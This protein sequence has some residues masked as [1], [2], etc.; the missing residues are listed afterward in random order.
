MPCACLRPV[1]L[2]L[3]PLVIQTDLSHG[4]VG[5]FI[6]HVCTYGEIL[7][8]RH[9]G[10]V[11]GEALSPEREPLE[12]LEAIKLQIGSDAFSAQ[13][14]QAPAPPGEAMVKRAW[15]VRYSELP[16]RSECLMTLQSWDTAS[17]GGPV[18]DW[19]VCTTW[20]LATHK[21]RYLADVWRRVD[22]PALRTA[23]RALAKQWNANRV[24][25]E[26]AGA[27]TSLVQELKGLVPGINAVK[28]E[29]DKAAVASAKIEAG[30]VLLP[31]RASWLPD[32][33]A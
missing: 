20:I 8:F 3:P 19:S 30:Q 29:G 24:L 9:N 31:E 21:R 32:L 16:P 12:I 13:Y 23:V 22:Y 18:N 2:Q 28:A 4:G 6:C 17:K 5:E 27:G 26:D 33:E 15:V 25:V 10:A 7:R 1:P 11:S 14:Q